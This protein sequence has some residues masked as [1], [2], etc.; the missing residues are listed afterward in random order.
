MK[1]LEYFRVSVPM[2]HSARLQLVVAI[3]SGEA[4]ILVIVGG[5]RDQIYVKITAIVYILGL[6][7]YFYPEHKLLLGLG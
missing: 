3:Q 5:G 7:D 4:S 2:V 1:G 6:I